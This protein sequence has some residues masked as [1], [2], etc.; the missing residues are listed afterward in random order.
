MLGQTI[1]EDARRL[2]PDH[3]K[4]RI[5]LTEKDFDRIKANLSDPLAAKAVEALKKHF[6]E[7]ENLP[8][9]KYEIP[10]GVR[11]LAVS[12]SVLDR[13]QTCAMLYKL[14]GDEKYAS[15]A[16]KE[17]SAAADFPD[18]HEL[19]FLDC[20]ELCAAFAIGY[21]WLYGYFT[22]EQRKKLSDAIFE[23]GIMPYYREYHYKPRNGYPWY[24]DMPGDNWKMVCDGGLAM[25]ILAIFEEHPSELYDELLTLAFNDCQRAVITFYS[26]EDG[27]YSEG[28][29][30]WG[31][32]TMY[33]LFYVD[34]LTASCGQDYGM[35]DWKGLQKSPYWLLALASNDHRSFNFGDA[36]CGSVI[37]PRFFW[38]GHR[39][40]DGALNAITADYLKKIGG[41][42]GFAGLC[43]Y[44]PGEI[45]SAD[46]L[47]TA[48]GSV[49]ADNAAFRS[50]WGEDDVFV[51]YH[52]GKNN[53]Y[54]GHLD[55]GNFILNVGSVRF[56]HDFNPD[57][58]NLKPYGG[59]YRFRAEG[60]NV[61]VINPSPERD[62]IWEA[63]T[64]IS[65]ICTEGR[66]YFAA[67]D[68]SPAYGGGRKLLR[69]VKLLG[70]TKTVLVRDEIN[71][72]P[73]DKV[74][75]YAQTEAQ[76]E[77]APDGKSA[78]LSLGGKRLWAG[79]LSD[80]RFEVRSANPD[81]NS[82]VV[83]PGPSEG[84]GVVRP[85][86]VN[87]CVKLTVVLTGKDN[88]TLDTVFVPLADGQT[89]PDTLPEVKEIGQ[90]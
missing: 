38:F 37:D 49:G 6:D 5:L 28:P 23:K 4:P 20:A 3:T 70:E 39:Y 55:M 88:Y 71:V 9:R 60:H 78:V 15:R 68:I 36:W 54:H 73:E 24:R 26:A 21:D 56:F 48:H 11:L 53:A 43:H 69:G 42:M 57:N 65:K 17:L 27:T 45:G 8:P 75:W 7:I 79:L 33:L 40:K 18:F 62:Q 77:L 10:D 25:A 59:C 76:V 46:G 81:E 63:G 29:M 16:W 12:R 82:P 34:S 19:H 67:A 74:L 61:I 47:P 66:D 35:S 64:A 2:H 44:Y 83:E 22:P 89:A 86:I 80:G 30:Y 32:A 84:D 58:Y 31:Y 72:L 14:F 1:L 87:D 51:G 50:G 85:Q 41:N 52:T 90:W 13:V